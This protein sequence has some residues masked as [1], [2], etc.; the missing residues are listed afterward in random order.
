MEKSAPSI[1][2][3]ALIGG[4]IFGLLSGIPFVGALNCACCSLVIASGFVAAFLY[5]KECRKSN[6][7]F[8]AG[9]GAK[10]GLMAGLVHGV[11]WTAV[12]G[13][14]QA[15]F[16]SEASF[17]EAIEQIRSNPQI[18][19][20]MADNFVRLFEF[21]SSAGILVFLFL[22]LALGVIFATIGGLIGGAAFKVEPEAPAPPTP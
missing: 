10:V 1:W 19:P 15:I 2:M 14:F 17:E 16:D 21:L 5:S 7:E 22:F 13:V 9:S 20:E 11:V 6:V 4:G 12:S 8:R 3:P 18:P